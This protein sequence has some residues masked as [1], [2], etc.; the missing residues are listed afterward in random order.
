M[1]AFQIA[2]LIVAAFAM[3]FAAVC[4][5]FDR[6]DKAAFYTAAAAAIVGLAGLQP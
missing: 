4:V 1:T 6:Y 5:V 2:D 3:I